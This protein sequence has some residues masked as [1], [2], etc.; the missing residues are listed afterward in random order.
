VRKPFQSFPAKPVTLI[1]F[2]PRSRISSPLLEAKSQPLRTWGSQ[3]F[4][5]PT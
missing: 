2:V 1:S 4:T 3:P 5:C